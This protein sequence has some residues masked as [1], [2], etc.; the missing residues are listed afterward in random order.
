LGRRPPSL[1]AITPR[2]PDKLV[3]HTKGKHRIEPD[4]RILYNSEAAAEILGTKTSSA[5]TRAV[6]VGLLTCV[7]AEG[8]KGVWYSSRMLQQYIK[9]RAARRT[10]ASTKAMAARKAKGTYKPP[11]VYKAMKRVGVP[12]D[13]ASAPAGASGPASTP[14]QETGKPQEQALP[15]AVDRSSEELC[16]ECLHRNT[17]FRLDPCNSCTKDTV[18]ARSGFALDVRVNR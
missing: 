14:P 13:P 9:R 16:K 12:V 17:D 10:L 15:F 8:V 2:G 11:S 18:G 6:A 5:V 7:R 3:P 1:P 4:G